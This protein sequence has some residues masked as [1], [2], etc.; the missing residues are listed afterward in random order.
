VFIGLPVGASS[1]IPGDYVSA[2]IQSSPGMMRFINASNKGTVKA[3]PP[4]VG[5]HT[6][7]F[8]IRLLRTGPSDVLSRPSFVAAGTMWFAAEFDHRAIRIDEGILA[9]GRQG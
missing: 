7:P 1:N 3:V 6:I 4:W 8:E 9:P 5:L 2:C